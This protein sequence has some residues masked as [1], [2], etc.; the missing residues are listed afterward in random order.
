MFF[1]IKLNFFIK[2]SSAAPQNLADFAS[3][4]ARIAYISKLKLD[5]FLRIA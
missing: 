3:K 4:P 2:F 1:F 5:L